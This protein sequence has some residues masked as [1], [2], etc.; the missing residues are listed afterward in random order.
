MLKLFKKLV[1]LVCLF[2]IM[3]PLSA[4][5]KN[6]VEIY[7]FYGIGCPHCEKEEIALKNIEKKYDN[8]TIKRYEVSKNVKNQNLMVKV[9]NLMKK[10]INGVP[11]TIIGN[12]AYS[13]YTEGVTDKVL[14]N[15]IK[16]YS[17]H[18]SGNP[19]SDVIKGNITLPIIGTINPKTFSLPIITVVF[20]LLD[21]FNPC[22][23]WILLF[24]LSML[25]GTKD[26][27]RMW[28]LGL[29]FI[30]SSA[31]TYYLF[32]AAWL[33][34]ALVIGNLYWIRVL[35]AIFAVGGGTL[36]IKTALKKKDGG[37]EVV[38]DKKR[39]KIF[40]RIKKFTKEKSLTIATIGVAT[41]A[42]SVNIVEMI[43]SAGFPAIY[44]QI[45]SMNHVSNV[46]YYLYLLLYV[47]FF[48]LDQVVIFAIAVKTMKLK[49][50]STK[51]G[52]IAH[53]VGGIIMILIGLLM[54]I[55]SSWLSF[56]G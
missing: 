17:E 19:V 37:C 12:S 56:G 26:H 28:T 48:I 35:I 16:Y 31:V 8:V 34:L 51:Y 41:L 44:S 29:T 33:N 10:K 52:N 5:A 50:I 55:N 40:D 38:E 23:L 46:G 25:I 9:A 53:Y 21:G 18:T 45:L 30:V 42:V 11:F 20:G 3:I 54:V 43:C 47:I 22:A 14:D 32:M 39:S 13:G 36:S 4:K 1:I 7:F 49:G 24:L 2:V 27:A 15:A 6:N